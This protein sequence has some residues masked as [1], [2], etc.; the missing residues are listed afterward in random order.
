LVQTHQITYLT[1]G[2]DLLRLSAPTE[3][4]QSTVV[5]ANPNYNS[6]DATTNSLPPTL[7]AHSPENTTRGNDLTD[8][9]RAAD[10]ATLSFEPLPGTAEEATEIS[11]E[12]PNAIVLTGTEATE[13]ALKLMQSPRILHIATHGFFLRDTATPEQNTSPFSS[14]GLGQSNPNRSD[15]STQPMS[16]IGDPLLRSGLALAGFNTRNSGTED[17][18]LTALEAASL[19]LSG[20][21]LVVLSACETG[22]GE[23]TNGEGVYG[24]RRAFVMA[25]AETQILSLW[26]VDDLATK[27]LM[28]GY[29]ELLQTNEGR[30][31]ALREVQLAFLDNP[32]YRHPY[33]W[34]AFIPSGDWQPMRP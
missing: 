1:S 15:A 23:A 26:R 5:I 28:V 32:D 33:Y 20:T 9:Q 14:G 22:V 25:G 34:A 7:V 13:N 8:N 29:Y 17:G 16:N 6:A 31:A 18:I 3:S 21:Q 12:I 2:R 24:L 19:D 27:D 10:M 11:Q 30:S 4:N